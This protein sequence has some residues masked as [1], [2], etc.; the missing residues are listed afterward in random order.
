MN[1]YRIEKRSETEP[2]M[3][4]NESV[5]VWLTRDYLATEYTE[6]MREEFLQRELRSEPNKFPSGGVWVKLDPEKE[7]ENDKCQE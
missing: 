3:Y 1:R 7:T 4:W 5:R 6:A 2:T